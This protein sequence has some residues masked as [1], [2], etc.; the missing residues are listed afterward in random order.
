MWTLGAWTKYKTM[1]SNYHKSA[2][3]QV[4]CCLYMNGMEYCLCARVCA[5]S[6]SDGS[7]E[8]KAKHSNEYFIPFHFNLNL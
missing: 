4:T 8:L 1:I 7:V 3:N 5:S 6:A 2:S